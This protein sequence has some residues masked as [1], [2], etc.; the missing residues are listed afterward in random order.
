M[1]K[2]IALLLAVCMLLP[3]FAACGDDK[4][5][6]VTTASSEETVVTK[7]PNTP[8]I[9]TP[10]EIGDISGEFRILVAGNYAFNDFKSEGEEGTAVDTAIY[11]RNAYLKDKYNIDI[12][13]DEIL[14]FMR[15]NGS[16]EGYMKIAQDHMAGNHTYDAASIGTWDVATLA[17]SGYIHDLNDKETMKYIDLTKPYWDQ[18]AN[19]D[20]MIRNKM[21]YTTGDISLVDNMS[22]N[23][24]LFNKGMRAAYG[25]DDPYE[26]V[27]SGDWTLEKFIE[28]A[29][30]VGEDANQ[31]GIYDENDVYG[32]MTWND[33]TLAV[34]AAAG[35][36]ICSID[37]NGDLELT[38][39]NERV[40]N[41][42][43]TFAGLY[44]DY[45]HTFN[46][47][48]DT[49]AGEARPSAE[50]DTN[51]TKMFDSDQV[52]FYF[53]TLITV[54][55]HRDS[56]TDFG[57]LPF[58]K[59]DKSQERYG[60]VISDYAGQYICVPEMTGDFA[61]A[62]LVLE[63]LAYQ[64]QK[65][66]TPAY[67]DQ[68]LIGQYMRDEESTEMLDIIFSSRV[69]D[70]GMYYKIGNYRD[71]LISYSRTHASLSSIYD[72]SLNAANKKIDTINL[73]FN[74]LNTAD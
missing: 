66:L 59:F 19:E 74:Q 58:P 61:R 23:A 10:E 20:L 55:R 47:Q 62:G 27:R 33:A 69:Y 48:Y 36:K 43:D 24:I 31:D 14:G 56:E 29:R 67:Y 63:E 60:H 44:F 42:F 8:D 73:F 6:A 30:A 38:F 52:L 64:G 11:R 70:V 12:A 57:I 21:Y 72:T 16:G 9:P 28:L 45:A 51:R 41:L 40:V 35:E 1:K 34:L 4:A 49:Q 15:I 18:R 32:L 3:M 17:Y 2:G 22:T 65:V 68:T 5:P 50:W 39:Y 71:S 26:L 25:L 37:K 13:Y 54:P 46:Y 7:D 53:T